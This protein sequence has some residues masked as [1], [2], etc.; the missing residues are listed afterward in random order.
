MK[1]CRP[2]LTPALGENPPDVIERYLI[3]QGYPPEQAHALADGPQAAGRDLESFEVA[4]ELAESLP[5]LERIIGKD[6]LMQVD[7]LEAGYLSA[8]AVGRVLI[9]NGSGGYGTGFLISPRLLLTN[10]H[11]LS[12]PAVAAGSRVEFN[13][14]R[15][16]DGGIGPSEVYELD[17]DA[18]FV[19]SAVKELDFTI[20]AVTAKPAPASPLLAYG[21]H[22]LTALEDE[23][24]AGA[25]VTIIQHPKGDPKQ[26]ALRENEVLKLPDGGQKF[27]HYKTGTH[28]GSSGSPVFNDAWDLVALHHAGKPE[29]DS[30]DVPLLVDGTPWRPGVSMDEIKWIANEGIR[31]VAIVD[32]VKAQPLNP[33]RKAR[34]VEALQPRKLYQPR[35]NMREVSPA[36]PPGKDRPRR[37][38]G[39]VGGR[40]DAG[41]AQGGTAPAL[42]R[43][44]RRA[45]RLRRRTR[46]AP[47]RPPPHPRPRLRPPSRRGIHR[48]PRSR[49]D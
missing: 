29:T 34:L 17:P 37:T 32:F 21:H 49:R 31:T 7:Y 6:M 11:V 12:T 23:I 9:G 19:S 28:P 13:Y 2:A 5:G 26:I 8:K 36:P 24:L 39:R 44:C 20:V 46:P 43:S 18:F 15:N 45:R 38:R 40:F 30:N 4:A 27:L 3:R 10:N 25:C 16:L 42:R 47:P 22:P 41:H 1:A 33:P 35:H 48:I 14:Q